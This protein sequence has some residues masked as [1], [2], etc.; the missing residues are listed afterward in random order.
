M[1]IAVYLGMGMRDSTP[2][3]SIVTRSTPETPTPSFTTAFSLEQAPRDSVRGQ[4]MKLEGLVLWQSRMATEPAQLREGTR[5]QQG[6][7]IVTTENSSLKVHFASQSAILLNPES[8][9]EIIQTLPIEHVFKHN[10]GEALYQSFSGSSIS[11]RSL[12]MILNLQATASA[13]LTT[14]PEIEEVVI[15]IK[16][17]QGTVAYNSPEFE[18]KL[19]SLKRGDIFV[20]DSS[21]RKG[22]F[23]PD[24]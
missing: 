10:Q 20:Y 15:D 1:A 23:E 14:Y 2:P 7:K 19:W 13:M 21:K 6:E 3:D 5:I 9:V 11:V 8:E 4:I 18:S 17:G 24:R 16:T 22:Y 12:N